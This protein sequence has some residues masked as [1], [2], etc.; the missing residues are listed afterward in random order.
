MEGLRPGAVDRLGL[1]RTELLN[2]NP[3]LIFASASGWGRDGS[4]THL[5]GHDINYLAL[6][7]A[8]GAIGPADGP[9]IP[10]VNFLADFGGGGCVLVSGICAALFERERSGHG[11]VV[12]HSM[13]DGSILLTAMIHGMIYAGKWNVTRGTNELDGAAPYYRCYETADHKFIAV[14]AIE[15]KFYEAF[16][17]GV[18]L[19]HKEWPQAESSRWPLLHALLEERFRSR[20]RDE[21]TVHFEGLDACVT[22][23]LSLDEA[24]ALPALRES[25]SYTAVDGVPQ[26]GVT[27]RFSRTPGSIHGNPPALGAHTHEVLG[28]LGLSPRE[29]DILLTSG[30][31]E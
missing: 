10:P 6:A 17:T 28:T 11:Q 24:S 20:S 22:P 5:A 7:G 1:G 15:P 29:I 9:P 4:L 26:P 3:A 21:W 19:H 16:L 27:P 13:L 12:D 14:G 18:G 31:A 25:S 30:T 8:L 2:L 23:V